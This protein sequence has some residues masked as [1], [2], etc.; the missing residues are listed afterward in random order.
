[1]SKSSGEITLSAEDVE[2]IREALLIGLTCLGDV[3][4]RCNALDLAE[5]LGVKWPVG[6][7]PMHPTGTANC[8]SKFATA[9]T[10]LNC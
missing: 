5:S 4:E 7:K 10:L 1:M 6:A 2:E 8:V 9:L 3:E